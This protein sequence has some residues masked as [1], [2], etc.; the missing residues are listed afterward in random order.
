MRRLHVITGLPKSGSTL[1]CNICNQNPTF[2]AGSTSVLTKILGAVSQVISTSDEVKSDLIA[3]PEGTES[4]SRETLQAVVLA[5]YARKEKEVVFDKSRA[6]PALSLLLRDLFAG[7]KMLVCV[8]DLRDIA[9]SVERTHRKNPAHDLFPEATLQTRLELLLSNDGMVGS[10]IPRILD[11]V[12]RKLDNVHFVKYAELTSNPKRTM[13]DIY[14]FLGEPVFEHD[15]DNVPSVATDADGMY[16][17]KHPHQTRPKVEPNTAHWSDVMSAEMA[18][19]VY[20]AF[21]RY[22]TALGFQI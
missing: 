13:A 16:M 18:N 19:G 17:N 14:E 5:H 8:R 7:S 21:P 15:F 20:A 3:D 22:N 12:D 9:A 1:L 11:L 6:W 10:V 2:F 4:R